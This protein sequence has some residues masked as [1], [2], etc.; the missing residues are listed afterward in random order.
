MQTNIPTHVHANTNNAR[1]AA[2]YCE[3]PIIITGHFPEQCL[4]TVTA[5]IYYGVNSELYIVCCPTIHV[6]CMHSFGIY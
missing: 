5:I 2:A 6:C 4:A 1:S 3:L